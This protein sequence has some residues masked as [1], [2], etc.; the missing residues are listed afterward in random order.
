MVDEQ[1]SCWTKSDWYQETRGGGQEAR[2]RGC[3]SVSSIENLYQD[4]GLTPN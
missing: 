4:S 2:R 1:E 3:V